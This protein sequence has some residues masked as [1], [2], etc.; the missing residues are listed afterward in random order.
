MTSVPRAGTASAT[1]LTGLALAL[2]LGNAAA[3]G[4]ARR[5]GLDVWNLPALREDAR[6]TE[7]DGALI[8]EQQEQL[9]RGIEATDH[10]TARLAAGDLSLAD[11]TD[12]A[13]PVLRARPGFEDVAPNYYHAPT[14]HLA[15]ARY[16]IARA[17]QHPARKAATAARLEAE[18]ALMK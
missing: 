6:T 3:P 8:Q 4:W 9:F 18:Y 14:F 17:E 13:E 15:V 10:V 2:V 7:R 1:G 16:L 12:R 5:A 11:A